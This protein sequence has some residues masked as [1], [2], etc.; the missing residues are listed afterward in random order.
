MRFVNFCP[1]RQ[2]TLF[3]GQIFTDDL[4][5]NEECHNM[6]IQERQNNARNVLRFHSSTSFCIDWLF[7]D[8]TLGSIKDFNMNF[9]LNHKIPVKLEL[10]LGLTVPLG[11]QYWVA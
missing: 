10:R 1:E 4:T 6:F 5:L 3:S 7:C 11:V 2:E 8:K 9:D